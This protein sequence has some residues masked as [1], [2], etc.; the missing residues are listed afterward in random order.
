MK[1]LI[2][3]QELNYKFM[4][5][6]YHQN[7]YD[8]DVHWTND[9]W[10]TT[11]IKQG[12]PIRKIND[13]ENIWCIKIILFDSDLISSYHCLKL[14]CLFP[15]EILNFAIYAKSYNN[16]SI[17]YKDLENCKP[18]ISNIKCFYKNIF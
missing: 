15:N 17:K 18:N 2:I 7:I 10:K 14:P 16:F 3:I 6:L 9:F 4:L 5:K 12:Y 11:K 8:V 13:D 1:D